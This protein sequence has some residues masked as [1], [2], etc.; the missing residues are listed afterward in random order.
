M[1]SAID[2][3]AETRAEAVF[4]LLYYNEKLLFPFVRESLG[5]SVVSGQSMNS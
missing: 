4:E 5:S 3:Q 2:D 1:I